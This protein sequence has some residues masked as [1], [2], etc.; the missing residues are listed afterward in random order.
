MPIL[1]LTTPANAARVSRAI[2]AAVPVGAPWTFTRQISE[3]GERLDSVCQH[4]SYGQPGLEAA[5]GNAARAAGATV[6]DVTDRAD[7]E[8]QRRGLRF[9]PPLPEEPPTRH[10]DLNEIDAARGVETS[11]TIAQR[12]EALQEDA[13][14]VEERETVA[15]VGR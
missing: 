3:T 6:I 9:R 7:A 14:R 2:D 1:I 11:G 4:V 12:W 13:R 10:A 8:L 5:V 15:E